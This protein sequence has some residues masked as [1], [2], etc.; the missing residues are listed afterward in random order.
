MHIWLCCIHH[1]IRLQ[2][3]AWFL[4]RAHNH[5]SRDIKKQISLLKAVSKLKDDM[6]KKDIFSDLD[7]KIDK[8]TKLY[9]DNLVRYDTACKLLEDS[10]HLDPNLG[11][12]I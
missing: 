2:V 12:L 11:K 1:L 10:R 8:L 9:D 3:D 5:G 6:N 7:S 4:F